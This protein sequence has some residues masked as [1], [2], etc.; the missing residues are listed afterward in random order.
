VVN[1]SSDGW[2]GIG[3]IGG[4][5]TQSSPY[6]SQTGQDGNVAS[7]IYNDNLNLWWLSFWTVSW[8]APGDTFYNAGYQAG[9]YVGEMDSGNFI[10]PRYF[11][12]D[13][14]GYNTA[15]STDQEWSDFLTGWA[16]GLNV[17]GLK[18]QAA[19]YC[20][21]SQHTTYNLGAISLPAFIAVTPILNN[22]PSVKGGNVKG[23]IA[24]YA[25]CP[26]ANYVNQVA[27]WG[28]TY[29][30]VQFDDSGVD[31]APCRLIC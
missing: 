4:M 2:P 25:S 13:P 27:S 22:S 17:Y 23:Y 30:T 6:T 16:D 12:L 18:S 1:T 20:N 29:N 10:I 15:A 9:K 3:D 5:G 24:Y 19:F 28:G 21:Q 7:A 26:A 11:V 31:C 8:P 14:E